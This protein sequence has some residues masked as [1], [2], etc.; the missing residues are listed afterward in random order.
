MFQFY[1]PSIKWIDSSH[2]KLT[3]LQK[4]KGWEA[5]INN[6]RDLN[7]L[8]KDQASNMK[9]ENLMNGLQI[10]KEEME[11]QFETQY[12]EEYAKLD[13][14]KK[15]FHLLKSKNCLTQITLT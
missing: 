15:E 9:V 12:N 8:L 5:V 10:D 13:K 1:A 11:E 4:N 14:S 3:F 2:C 6:C 7:Q